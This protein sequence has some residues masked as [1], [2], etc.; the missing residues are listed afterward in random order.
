VKGHKEKTI[1]DGWGGIR[2]AM[3]QG[4]GKVPEEAVAKRPRA[5][6]GEEASSR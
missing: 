1:S 5:P 3:V 4:W 2:E 6:A